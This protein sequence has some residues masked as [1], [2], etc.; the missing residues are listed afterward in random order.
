MAVKTFYIDRITPL[1][2]LNSKNHLL[3]SVYTGEEISDT[4]TSL[5]KERKKST[6]LWSTALHRS[7][8]SC[9]PLW[10]QKECRRCY[11]EYPCAKKTNTIKLI[12][13]KTCLWCLHKCINA[14]NNIYAITSFM[15]QW[16]VYKTVNSIWFTIKTQSCKPRGETGADKTRQHTQ[17]LS[18][19]LNTL[20]P[21]EQQES[22][23]EI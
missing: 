21:G 18:L 7:S 4:V 11:Q 2:S 6:F 16:R 20:P 1:F 17:Q 8:P 3:I 15:F 12:K 23:C 13:L 9:S 5:K 19:P 22:L 10:T 14:A